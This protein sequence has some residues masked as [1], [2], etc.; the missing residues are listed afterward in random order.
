MILSASEFYRKIRSATEIKTFISFWI[1]V[2]SQNNTSPIFSVW[3]SPQGYEISYL[4]TIRT[5]VYGPLFW[6]GSF[7]NFESSLSDPSSEELP[8]RL[9][10]WCK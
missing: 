7:I 2:F 4:R 6:R 1:R 5:L 10:L 3:N 9:E 8:N